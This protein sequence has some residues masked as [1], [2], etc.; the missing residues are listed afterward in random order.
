M[1][2]VLLQVVPAP[3]SDEGSTGIALP[4]TWRPYHSLFAKVNYRVR[5]CRKLHGSI[6]GLGRAQL[7]APCGVERTQS[8]HALAHRR[9][10]DEQRR[11]A[12]LGERIDRVERLRC[13]RRLEWKQL[14]RLL[15]ADQRVGEAVRR[16]AEPGRRPV[17]RELAF[18]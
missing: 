15:E 13:R 7:L 14:F 9:M 10:G 18:R 17:G 4:Q 3:R 5:S 6:D 2:L 12:F 8:L 11:E 1:P 16:A